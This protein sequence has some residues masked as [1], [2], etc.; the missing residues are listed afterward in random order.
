MA[1]L[2]D[3]LLQVS[4]LAGDL[5]ELAELDLNPVIARPDGAVAVDARARLTPAPH[6]D[7]F[8][9]RLRWPHG[10]CHGQLAAQAGAGEYGW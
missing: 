2:T 7:P 9:R 3:V 8:L 10:A 4:R 6:H 5:P 1:A